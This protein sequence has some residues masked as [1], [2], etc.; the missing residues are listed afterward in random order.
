MSRPERFL[1]HLHGVSGGREPRL[2]AVEST[3]PGVADVT[4]VVYDHVPEPG[5]TT[6]ITYGLSMV[7]HPLWTVARP[8]LTLTVA[9]MDDAWMLALGEVAERLRG[10]CPFVYGSTVGLANDGVSPIDPESGITGFAVFAPSVLEREDYDSIELAPDDRIS[11]V[12]LYPIH[13]SE[14]RF[15]VD[16][17]LE[18]FWR[19][20]WDPYDVTRAAMV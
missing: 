8:E 12:G 1:A 2:L 7:D 3:K 19:L 16:H 4:V 13:E 11:I 17:G 14:R 10:E 9:T 18:E 20:G 6:G 5:M 15:I